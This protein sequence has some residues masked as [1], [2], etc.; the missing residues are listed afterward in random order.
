MIISKQ[1]DIIDTPLRNHTDISNSSLIE[2]D[3]MDGTKTDSTR[4]NQH[5]IFI[6][7]EPAH[8]KRNKQTVQ[9]Q[10]KY[11]NSILKPAKNKY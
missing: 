11:R 1:S 2:I 10:S 8:N 6:P 4:Q 5:M 7:T 3:Y 9:K